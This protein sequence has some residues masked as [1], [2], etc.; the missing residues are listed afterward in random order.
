M[1]KQ[2]QH[3]SKGFW[4]GKKVLVTG[5]AGFIGSHL[6][7]ELLYLGAKVNVVDIIPKK[8]AENLKHLKNSINY[9]KVDLKKPENV[10]KTLQG[11][12]VV[13][14]LASKVGGI[15][16]NIIHPA[17]MLVDN[18]AIAT[19][20]I[21]AAR[22]AEVERLLVVSSACV[23]PRFC[24]IPTPEE[25]G[26][27]DDPEP[28]NF[29]YG[30]AKRLAELA[31]KTY[32]EEYGMKI[33]IVRPYNTYGPRDH[34][35]EERSHVIPALIKRVFTGVNPLPV[36]GSGNQSR[37]FIYVKDLVRGMLTALEKYPKADPINLGTDKEIKIKDLVLKILKI[38]G[39]NPRMI[40]DTTKPEG[41]PRRNC[42][43]TKAK[44]ILGFKAETPLET[45]LSETIRW[46]QDHQI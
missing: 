32:S 2:P 44:K 38:T 36:W 12:N 3:S 40:F 28:T 41:Q 4:K 30:W 11:Q 35:E 5:G 42:D 37:S 16:Y 15:H 46:Y 29:G 17:T 27:K 26:F 10:T 19:N 14:H 43:N 34:F 24:T 7:D 31:A 13:F 23:Y 20:T 9:I 33:G 45:G 18:V 1:S 8:F 22:K 21:E 39:E 6:V 25:E